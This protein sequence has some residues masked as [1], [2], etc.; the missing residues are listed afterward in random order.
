MTAQE[1]LQTI[2]EC[3]EK[4][5]EKLPLAEALGADTSYLRSLLD[6]LRREAKAIREGFP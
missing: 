1:E 5:A 4:L 2:G 3:I 6:Q